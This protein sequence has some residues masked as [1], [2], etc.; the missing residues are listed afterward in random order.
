MIDAEFVF[1]V[2]EENYDIYFFC[3]KSYTLWMCPCSTR[4][5]K[6]LDIRIE[7]GLE[8]SYVRR[9]KLYFW[10]PSGILF[11]DSATQQTTHLKSFV[12]E[13]SFVHCKN[14]VLFF[15]NYELTQ[16][17]SFDVINNSWK[18]HQTINISDFLRYGN[19]LACGDD[20]YVVGTCI[21]KKYNLK[22]HKKFFEDHFHIK[23][24]HTQK[25]KIIVKTIDSAG[26]YKLCPPECLNEHLSLVQTPMAVVLNTPLCRTFECFLMKIQVKCPFKEYLDFLCFATPESL[27]DISVRVIKEHLDPEKATREKL[28]DLMGRDANF[29]IPPI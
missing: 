3:R 23:K 7:P 13:V 18:E 29:I 9:G 11:F 20:A 17:L 4:I 14:H 19:D 27:K 25:A 21:V 22:N 24:S 16:H 12:Q 5:W 6:R 2:D 28:V 1:V 26:N 15:F 8:L 10:C